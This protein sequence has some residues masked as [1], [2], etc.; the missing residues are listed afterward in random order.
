MIELEHVVLPSSDLILAASG[1][2]EEDK[3][4]DIT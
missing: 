4:D 3:N 1:I 2:T